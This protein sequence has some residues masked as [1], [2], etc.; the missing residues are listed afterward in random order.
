MGG[1]ADL[2]TA[3]VLEAPGFINT[4]GS[5]GL[6]SIDSNSVCGIAVLGTKH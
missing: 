5:P 1:K 2:I 6:E 3:N 4:N